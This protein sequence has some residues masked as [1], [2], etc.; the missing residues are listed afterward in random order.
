MFLVLVLF[1]FCIIYCLKELIS[2]LYDQIQR[3]KAYRAFC[4]EY[5][6]EDSQKRYLVN[7]N[8]EKTEN[9]FE[10]G[11]PRW[12][13][14]NRDGSRDRRTRDNYIIRNYSYLYLNQYEVAT[15]L[16]GEML[17]L[18]NQLR[19]KNVVIPLC[20]EE[21]DKY[22]LFLKDRYVYAA[23]WDIDS[24]I[25][26]YEATPTDFEKLCA[27]VFRNLGYTAEV[28]QA[29]NDG[30]YD[31]KMQKDGLSYLV[32]CKCYARSNH[33]GRPLIQKLVGA[34]AVEEADELIFIT[35]SS[36]TPG[37]MAYASDCN[38]HLVDG[39]LFLRLF[40][41]SGLSEEQEITF[42]SD[43]F[44]LTVSDLDKYMPPDF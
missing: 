40:R 32:E 14:S 2:Y 21:R 15:K 25:Q 13:Y 5:S 42:S 6:L 23:N 34:N 3:A 8:Y 27:A 39:T 44:R 41:D 26:E 33:V 10:L 11:F 29:T 20:K 12:R 38:V 22:N 35:T 43:D 7:W 30:G 31:I 4:D 36:F 37:A 17:Y 18:V 19:E 9:H 28:T 16:P 24:L 1:L